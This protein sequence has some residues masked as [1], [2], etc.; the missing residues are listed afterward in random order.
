[1][2]GR[3]L[4]ISPAPPDPA[5]M[6]QPSKN[7]LTFAEEQAIIVAMRPTVA[8]QRAQSREREKYSADR[9]MSQARQAAARAYWEAPLTG[10]EWVSF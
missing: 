8:K 2:S 5:E 7:R 6:E 9:R 1:M 10:T 4:A 3:G